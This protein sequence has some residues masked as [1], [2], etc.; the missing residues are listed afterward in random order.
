MMLYKKLGKT[1]A[2]LHL[3]KENGFIS[4][5]SRQYPTETMTNEDH[6]D[7]LSLLTKIQQPKQNCYCLVKSKEQTAKE[8]KIKQS[9]WVLN[10][11]ELSPLKWQD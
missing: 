9:T 1:K 10:K 8:K 6:T 3:I 7:D 11:M 2:F 5:R 4:L